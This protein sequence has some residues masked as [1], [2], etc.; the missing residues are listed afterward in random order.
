MN[1]IS[2]FSPLT[3][4]QLF[5]NFF[6]LTKVPLIFYVRPKV[7]SINEKR[8][9][10]KIPFRR[11]TKNHLNSMYFGALCIGSDIAGGMIAMYIMNTRK[12]KLSL[13]FKDLKVDFIKRPESDVYFTC[14]DGDKINAMIRKSLETGERINEPVTIKA[15]ISPEPNTEVYAQFVL[16][17]S[18]KDTS[19]RK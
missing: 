8:V 15:T 7:I 5:L 18:L 9:V 13:A 19:K 10:I 1:L 3:Q 6:G 14:E 11:R 4:A 2:K 16:T 12:L 17:L